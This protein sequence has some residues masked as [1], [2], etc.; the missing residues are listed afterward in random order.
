[1]KPIRFGTS[2]WGDVITDT[3]TFANIRLVARVLF[4]V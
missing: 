2:D 3:F 1:M 4:E